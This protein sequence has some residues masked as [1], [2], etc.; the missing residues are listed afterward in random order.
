M[1]LF[2]NPSYPQKK[3]EAK[4]SC[5]FFPYFFGYLFNLNFGRRAVDWDKF[6]IES[7]IPG[8]ITPP[9]YIFGFFTTSKVVAVPKSII[10]QFDL[11]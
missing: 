3:P 6:S 11:N 4:A 5:V 9:S 8:A 10:I 2:I 7:F 1:I